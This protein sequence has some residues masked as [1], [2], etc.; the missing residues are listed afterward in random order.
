[1][2]RKNPLAVIEAFKQA[3][4]PAEPVRLVIKCVNGDSNPNGLAAM[5]S[6]AQGFPI[7]IWDGYWSAAEICDLME[8]CDVYVSLHHAEGAGLTITD[9]LALGKPV[10]A[11][12]WSGNMDFMNVGNSFPVRSELIQLE[13]NIGSYAMGE[14]WAE[15]SVE[16]A[17]EFMRF[18]YCNPDE[19]RARGQVARQEIE[20]MYS[21]QAIGVLLR[22]RLDTIALRR[23][24][25]AFKQAMHEQHNRY[26]QLP[27]RISAIAKEFLPSNC[28]VLVVSKGDEALIKLGTQ[29]GWHFPQNEAGEYA[30]YY[31]AASEDAIAHLEELRQKGA[32]F[33]LFPQTALWWLEHYVAF[34]EYLEERYRLLP[35]PDDSCLIFAL[36]KSAKNR[37]GNSMKSYENT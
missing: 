17:A 21:E 32:A 6:L 11:T 10:I 16:D 8:A 29:A 22:Q 27:D 20:T 28:I 19:A 35:T 9:A 5:R 37:D 31:P 18:V 25:P 2:Q 1:M 36:D 15:P 24:F 7:S 26:R 34:R 4:D 33:L 14:F 12:G 30:G 23:N 13:E 3:F